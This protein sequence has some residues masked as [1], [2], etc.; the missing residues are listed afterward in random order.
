[1]LLADYE[2]FTV[3]FKVNG[4]VHESKVYNYGDY[5]TSV[6]PTIE[7]ST[8]VG[9]DQDLAYITSDITTNAIYVKDAF[10]VIFV[11]DEGNVEMFTP[12]KF[13]K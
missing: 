13:K 7:G 10:N 3:T 11:D 9:W 6:A 12:S 1:M 8:F 4:S 5:A 2:Q